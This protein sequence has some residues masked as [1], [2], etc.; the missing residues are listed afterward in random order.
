MHNITLLL[1]RHKPPNQKNAL[2]LSDAKRTREEHLPYGNWLTSTGKSIMFNFYNQPLLVRE[3]D[4]L[5][6]LPNTSER[7]ADIIE[8]ETIYF[9][10]ASMSEREKMREATMTLKLWGVPVRAWLLQHWEKDLIDE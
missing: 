4:G 10:D 5:L 6:T 2:H 7:P 9:Y 8:G 1:G 3:A